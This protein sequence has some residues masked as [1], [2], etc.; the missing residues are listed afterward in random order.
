[1]L[2]LEQRLELACRYLKELL[3][4]QNPSNA[5]LPNLIKLRQID[6]LEWQ[7]TISQETIELNQS[8]NDEWVQNCINLAIPFI[9]SIMKGKVSLDSLQ[10]SISFNATKWQR[11]K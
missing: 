5:F 2:K 11:Y 1:M 3:M 8:K 7:I 6:V 10:E 9:K 4:I